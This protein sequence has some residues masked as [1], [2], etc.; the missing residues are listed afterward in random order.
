VARAHGRVTEPQAGAARQPRVDFSLDA[1]GFD[2]AGVG[3]D[4]VGISG[5]SAIAV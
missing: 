3:E 1:H 5:A 4:E 2:V